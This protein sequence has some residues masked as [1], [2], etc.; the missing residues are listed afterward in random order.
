MPNKYDKFESELVSREAVVKR[1]FR[2]SALFV[3]SPAVVEVFAFAAQSDIAP[4]PVHEVGEFMFANFVCGRLPR[5][6]QLLQFA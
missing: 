4:I 5:V 1:V 3:H 6:T 2:H